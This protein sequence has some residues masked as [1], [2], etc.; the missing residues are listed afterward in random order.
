[1]L[2]T[3]LGVRLSFSKLVPYMTEGVDVTN[4]AWGPIFFQLGPQGT[5][6]GVDVTNSAWG[7]TF[8]PSWSPTWWMGSMLLTLLGDPIF[9]KLVSYMT[10]GSMLLTLLGDRPF[11]QVGRQG[12]RGGVDVTNSAWGPTFFQVGPLHDGRGRCY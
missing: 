5:R 11:F 1:M 8:F 10:E 7:P 6:G 4:S 12:T 3:L 2:L 9:S